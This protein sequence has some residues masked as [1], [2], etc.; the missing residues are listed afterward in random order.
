MNRG[1]SY[2]YF[3]LVRK[4]KTDARLQRV[5]TEVNGPDLHLCPLSGVASTLP[6][7]PVDAVVDGF[8]RPTVIVA[9]QV[10][11]CPAVEPPSSFSY[12]SAVSR[13]IIIVA[14]F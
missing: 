10:G 6:G 5:L 2:R 4:T 14:I 7:M 13:A 9:I 3:N 1:A 12:H 8:V 11:I